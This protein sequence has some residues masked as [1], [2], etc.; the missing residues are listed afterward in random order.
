M[1]PA[2]DGLAPS[3]LHV[4]PD[5]SA[6]A[7]IRAFGN[8]LRHTLVTSDGELPPGL[9]SSPRLKAARSFPPI[10]GLPLPGRMQALARAMTPFDLVLTHGWKALDVAMA[11]TLFQ[12]A[13]GLPALVHHEHE[14]DPARSMRRT[15]YRR[16]ALGKARGVI[17][18]DE[19]LEAAAL[20]DWQQPLGRVTTIPVARL[21]GGRLATETIS[22]HRRLYARA[23]RQEF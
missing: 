2:N 21:S 10:G 12:D 15:W 16:L 18:P 20:V 19:A 22:A 14:P 3:V 9:V 11:H 6:I 4:L 5:A 7:L 13:M 8:G 1:K 17:V 23:M